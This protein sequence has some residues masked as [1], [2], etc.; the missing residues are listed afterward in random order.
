M[1]LGQENLLG[2]R[3][4]SWATRLETCQQFAD[5]IWF[6]IL[7][8]ISIR[9]FLAQQFII[10]LFILLYKTQ[11]KD[12]LLLKLLNIVFLWSN[13]LLIYITIGLVVWFFVDA[14]QFCT[15]VNNLDK[16]CLVFLYHFMGAD[17]LIMICEMQHYWEGG[18]TSWP[19]DKK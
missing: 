3:L 16:T 19:S 1:K 9:N 8:L 5:W 6:Y 11:L 7:S 17:I 15:N 4:D 13:Y 10:T 14:F 12:H 2:A 18:G